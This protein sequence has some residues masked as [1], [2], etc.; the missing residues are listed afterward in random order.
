[1]PPLRPVAGCGVVEATA[2][3]GTLAKAV[4]GS[5]PECAPALRYLLWDPGS[6]RIISVAEH[7]ASKLAAAA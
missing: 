2:G 1:M 6:R 7:E 3:V 4:L 5:S